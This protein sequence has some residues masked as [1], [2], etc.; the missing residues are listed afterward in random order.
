MCEKKSS[1]CSDS[2]EAKEQPEPCA[3]EQAP[4][5]DSESQGSCCTEEKQE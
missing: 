1:C 3:E 4:E 2:E 5:S